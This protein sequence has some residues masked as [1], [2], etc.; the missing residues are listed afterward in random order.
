MSDSGKNDV[1]QQWYR[2]DKN[3]MQLHMVKIGDG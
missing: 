1:V 3:D 2:D